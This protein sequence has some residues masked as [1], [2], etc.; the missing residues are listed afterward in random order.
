VTKYSDYFSG[1][2]ERFRNGELA[3]KLFSEIEAT[4]IDYALMEKSKE[5]LLVRGDFRW[6]DVGSYK[7]FYEI[8]KKD[9]NSNVKIGN[10]ITK[11]TESCLIYSKNE[12]VA[13]IGAKNLFIIVNN[14]KIVVGDI[15]NSQD[16]KE[17]YEYFE[18]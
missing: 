17:A 4:S 9:E 3:D 10:V 6:S 14:G 13:V 12:P 5:I 15:N 2:Y 16:V 1:F 8:N 18:K 7:S 11:N